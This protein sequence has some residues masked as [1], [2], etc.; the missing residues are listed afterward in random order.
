M[1]NIV[2][3]ASSTGAFRNLLK[4][5]ESAGL[6]STLTSKRDYTIFAPSDSAFAK[7][8]SDIL[9]EIMQNPKRLRQLL[10][11]HIVPRRVYSGDVSNGSCT[12]TMLGKDICFDT[13]SGTKVENSTIVDADI[14]CTN[15]IIHMID[16]VL[17]PK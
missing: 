5:I 14:Q 6:T 3:T 15:G 1:K 16:T 12:K 11:Y 2:D 8:P 10:N 4:A 17:I 13:S 9:D 7:I